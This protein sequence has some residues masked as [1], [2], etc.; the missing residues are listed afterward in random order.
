MYLVDESTREDN[1]G[2]QKNLPLE[3][4]RIGSKIWI[5]LLGS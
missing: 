1:E 4:I 5:M 2:F 3:R